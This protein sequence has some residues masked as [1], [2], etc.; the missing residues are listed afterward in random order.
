MVVSHHERFTSFY[1]VVC[2]FADCPLASHMS[3]TNP[4][5]LI[6]TWNMACV[7]EK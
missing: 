3:D 6:K 1:T 5:K 4:Q 2:A 7:L